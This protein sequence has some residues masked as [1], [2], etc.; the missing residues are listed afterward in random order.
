MKYCSVCLSAGLPVCS[1]GALFENRSLFELF[2]RHWQNV[3]FF[4]FSLLC[5]GGGGGGGLVVW[6]G[7]GGG[8]L[9]HIFWKSTASPDQITGEEAAETA[10]H[11]YKQMWNNKSSNIKR[12]INQTEW[13]WTQEVVQ[14]CEALDV[15]LEAIYSS[16]GLLID[17][18]L[19]WR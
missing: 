9:L 2:H 3:Q 8:A 15:L 17:L 19:I 1:H 5:D 14:D 13:K 10:D 12:H 7:G 11:K 4:V 6:G 18:N 16:S